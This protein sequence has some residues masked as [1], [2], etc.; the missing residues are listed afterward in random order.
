MNW[1]RNAVLVAVASFTVSYTGA[2]ALNPLLTDSHQHAAHGY[3]RCSQCNCPAFQPS[4]G[5]TDICDN[6]G[7]KYSTHW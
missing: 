5:N 1:L 4:P 3:G 6:C 7:H 2:Q